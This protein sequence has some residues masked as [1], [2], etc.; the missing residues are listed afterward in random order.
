MKTYKGIS[1]KGTKFEITGKFVPKFLRTKLV[2]TGKLYSGGKCIEFNDGECKLVQANGKIVEVISFHCELDKSN[3]KA[4]ILITEDMRPFIKETLHEFDE[5][6]KEH[7]SHFHTFFVHGWESHEITIDDRILEQE[8]KFNLEYFKGKD[9]ITE[10]HIREQYNKKIQEE[11]EIE[12]I[13]QER[14]E[15]I[16]KEENEFLQKYGHVQ[17]NILKTQT[18]R[19]GDGT[20]IVATV[21]CINKNTGEKLRFYCRNIFD[22]GYVINPAYPVINGVE[23]GGIERKGFWD[24]TQNSA[25]RELTLFEKDCIDILRLKPPISNHIRM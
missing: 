13:E 5:L 7:L 6:E 18:L 16:K 25:V 1:E 20:D 21:E 4:A 19:G 8:I 14:R 11:V 22:F 24:I 12:K 3:Q 17:V 10:E 23:P 9:C 15:E 2:F